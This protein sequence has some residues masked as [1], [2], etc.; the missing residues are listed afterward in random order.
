MPFGQIPNRALVG[1]P[2]LLVALDLRPFPIGEL[3]ERLSRFL[4]RV[5]HGDG[6]GAS[7][8]GGYGDWR[9]FA[10]PVEG[11]GQAGEQSLCTLAG[12]A[13]GLHI[14]VSVG[15]SVGTLCSAIWSSLPI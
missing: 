14:A 6:S 10:P 2:P 8:T 9:V 7:E 15:R 11:R 1:T 12:T 5:H 3:G 13:L 4:D